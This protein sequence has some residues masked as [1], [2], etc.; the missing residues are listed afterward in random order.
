METGEEIASYVRD[1]SREDPRL[2]IKPAGLPNLNAILLSFI[3]VD[4]E[5]YKTDGIGLVG[6]NPGGVGD[7]LGPWWGSGD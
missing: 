1:H 2:V 5:R 6:G 4:I 7:G 3:I